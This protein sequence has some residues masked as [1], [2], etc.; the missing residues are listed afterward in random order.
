MSVGR[1]DSQRS[2]YHTGFVCGDLFGRADRYRLFREKVLP[3]LLSLRGRLESLYCENNGRPAIDPVILCGVTLLQFLE[4]VT[5]R[6]AVESV[7]YH[8]GWKYALDLELPYEGFHPTV[9]V[10]FR[11]RLEENQAERVLFDGIVDLLMELGLIKRGGK[12]RIDS[13]HILGCV[14]EMSRLECA[15]QTVRLALEELAGELVGSQRPEFWDRFWV[16]YVQS[17]VGWRLSKA[18]RDSRYRQCG[19]DMKELA[20]WVDNKHPKLAEIESVKLLRRVFEEQFELVEGSVQTRRT[21]PSRAVQNPHDPD[22]HYADK[23]TKQWIG[24]KVHVMESVD[25]SQPAKVIAEPGEHFITEILTT[26]AAQDEMAGLTEALKRQQEH[27]EIKPAAVYADGGYVTES[28]LAQAESSAME[29]LGPT[30]PDPHKGAYNADGFVVD[31]DKERAVCPQGKTSTQCSLINDSH[32]GTEY[33]RL[34]W[35][36][37]CDCCPVHKQCTRAKS[38]RRMLV[39]GLRHDLVQKRREEMRA[40]NFSQSMHPRNGIEGTHSELVRGHGL[41][42]TKYRGVNRV[43]LSH[44]LMGA[45]CN[46]KRYLKRLAFQIEIAAL[47]PA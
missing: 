2:F 3:Q 14:K 24:Y 4:K 27:H 39:V 5:D 40:E 45:A 35:G 28:T 13:T 21:R 42:R 17:E 41:R 30:R 15:T 8:L 20:Q 44:Y 47:N 22:A 25:P 7:V 33:Y 37:Q 6:G 31:V 34:E 19:Q 46:V 43:A 12:Q 26:E 10:Y 11:D 32:M 29:L 23:G 36:S 18:E 1:L 9:L 16:L 38:G